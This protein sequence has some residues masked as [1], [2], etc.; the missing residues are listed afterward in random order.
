MVGAE[1][2]ECGLFVGQ[3]VPDDDQDGPADGDD[4]FLLSSASGDAAVAFAEE[5]VGSGRADSGL[6]QNPGQVA[7]AVSGRAGAFLLPS[8]FLDAGGELRPL[9]T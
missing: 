7:I 5:S 4:G 6:A 8:G 2:G 1:V 9:S 3:Q